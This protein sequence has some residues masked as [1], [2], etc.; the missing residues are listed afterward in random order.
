[1][2]SRRRGAPVRVEVD[3]PTLLDVFERHRARLISAVEELETEDWAAPSRCARW[4]VADVVAHL[5]W[6]TEVALELIRRVEAGSDERLFTAFDPRTT[7]EAELAPLRDRDPAE[8]IAVIRSGTGTLVATARD[9][10]ARGV[11]EE[12]DTPLGWVPWPLSVNH[13]L[14]DSWLHERD[15]LVPLRAAPAPDPVEVRLVGSYQLVILG[16]VLSMFGMRGTVDLRLEG[17]CG[18]AQRVRVGDEVVVDS[19]DG[20]PGGEGCITGEA[21]A[22]IEAMSG[23]GDL[24]AVAR[25]PEAMLRP[26]AVLGARLAGM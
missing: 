2:S 19:P 23:R 17:T 9:L 5:R 13:L 10:V 20:P 24:T 22:V 16:S 11:E 25:G 7:P 4:T 12:A 3:P 18:G 26:A 1:M 14:W 21:V 6:G 15:V 8:H